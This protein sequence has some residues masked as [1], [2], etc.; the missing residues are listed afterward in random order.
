[1]RTDEYGGSVENRA[2]FVLEVVDA[3]VKTIG[4]ERVGIRLSPYVDNGGMK[5]GPGTLE[6][7]AYLLKELEIRGLK[8]GGRLAYI[9]TVENTFEAKNSIGEPIIIRR[10]L[11]FVRN[12]WSGVW[13]RTQ[14][15]DRKLAL[16]FVDV[17]DKL[18]IG[19][20][21]PFIAN[22]D[23]VHRFK[24]DLPLN[25]FDFKTFY[26]NGPKGY[27]DYPFYN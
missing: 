24:E 11:E 21:K 16:E 3:I 27:I 14:K 8:P 15:F 17:D 19:F 5:H 4:A 22:P 1:M 12:V 13:I 2:R 9:H 10:P 26:A 6:Q 23:L 25:D 18:L 7:Y 20:G